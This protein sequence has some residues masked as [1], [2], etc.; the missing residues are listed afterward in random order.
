MKI[1]Q[2]TFLPTPP[3]PH[4]SGKIAMGG[5]PILG[6]IAFLLTSVSKICLGGAVSYPPSPLT[7]YVHL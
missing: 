4:F 2:V 5:P 7:L 3:P 1:C 6:F